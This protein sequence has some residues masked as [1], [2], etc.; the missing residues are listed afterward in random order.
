VLKIREEAEPERNVIL[1]ARETNV[2]TFRYRP[3]PT[4]E[5]GMSRGNKILSNVAETLLIPILAADTA[6]DNEQSAWVPFLLN[7]VKLRVN[8]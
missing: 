2:Y 1:L 4:E 7:L 6:S 8:C 5:A 3:P